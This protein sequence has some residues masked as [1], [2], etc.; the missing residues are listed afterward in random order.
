LRDDGDPDEDFLKKERSRRM[1]EALGRLTEEQRE[2]LILSRYHG[3]KYEEIAEILKWRGGTDV[4]LKAFDGNIYI[5][6]M[7]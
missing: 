2:V 1:K 6:K 3:L 4:L 7:Q 5:R